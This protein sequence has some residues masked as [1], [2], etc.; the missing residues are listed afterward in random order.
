MEIMFVCTG[1]TCRSSMAAGLAAALLKQ[2][3]AVNITITSAGTMAL[4][5]SPAASQA[6]E[7]LAAQGIDITHHKASL[8]TPELAAAADLIL[9]MTA[10]HKAQVQA[11]QPTAADKVYTLT[12]YIG[13]Q[14]DIADPFGQSVAVYQACAQQLN[15]LITLALAKIQEKNAGN[16]DKS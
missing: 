16:D 6:V 5:G 15:Q 13:I 3:P 11:L 4:P 2:S 9:T 8:L 7:V 14:G 1:N 10:G 12:E